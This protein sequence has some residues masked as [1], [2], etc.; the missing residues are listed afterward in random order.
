MHVNQFTDKPQLLLHLLLR[1]RNSN[2]VDRY[3][4]SV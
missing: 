2:R 1:I 4:R 3:T